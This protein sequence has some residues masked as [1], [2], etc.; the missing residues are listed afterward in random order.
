L[1]RV[2]LPTLER[3]RMPHLN[4]MKRLFPIHAHAIAHVPQKPA[5]GLDPR[6]EPV[7]RKGHA[8][9]KTQSGMTIRRKVILL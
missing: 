9:P 5:L 7:L 3:P 1:N 8:K 2:D 6:V 4:P